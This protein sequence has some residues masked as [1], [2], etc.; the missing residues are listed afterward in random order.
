MQL[1]LYQRGQFCCCC[2]FFF[3]RGWFQSLQ[4]TNHHP[5]VVAPSNRLLDDH[6]RGMTEV[7]DGVRGLCGR[8][9]CL[10]EWEA[11]DSGRRFDADMLCR[12]IKL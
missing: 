2:C 8:Q 7:M 9:L 5:N 4:K 6:E 12:D 3:L 11:L 10:Y 1:S